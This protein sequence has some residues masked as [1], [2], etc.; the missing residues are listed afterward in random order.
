MTLKPTEQCLI[1]VDHS[2]RVVWTCAAAV[3]VDLHVDVLP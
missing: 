1:S 2:N 3:P